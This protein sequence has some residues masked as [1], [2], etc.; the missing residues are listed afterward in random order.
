MTKP[1]LKWAGRKSQILPH[2]DRFIDEL[3]SCGVNNFNY[4]EP[5]LGSGA[6]FF[7]LNSLN[8]IKKANLNDNLLELIYFY[9]T[10]KGKEYASLYKKIYSRSHN[11]NSKSSYEEKQNIYYQWRKNIMV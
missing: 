4:H 1:I 7:H 10:I 11:Y 3:K 9:K 2:L 6:V 8:L 5:F